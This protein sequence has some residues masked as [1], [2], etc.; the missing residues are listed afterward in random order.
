MAERIVDRSAISMYEQDQ[1]KYFIVINRRRAIPDVR[2]GLKPVQRRVLYGAFVKHLTA[3]SKKRKSSALA[4]IIME[5]FHPHSSCY[6]SIV[7]MAQWFNNKIPMMYGFGNWGSISGSG[8]ASERYTETAL[9]DF[10]YDVMIEELDQSKNIVDWLDTY[11]RDG[12]KEPE[13]LPAKLPML[14]I[15]G[16]FGIGG[17]IQ[18]NIPSHNPNEVIE[19]TRKLLKNPNADVV[20]IPDLCQPCDLI[21]TDW[22]EISHTGSGTFKVRGRIRQEQ[23]KKGNWILHIVSIPD[24]TSTGAIYEKIMDLIENKQLP[25]I[26][27]CFDLLKV[28]PNSVIEEA[29][30]QIHLKPGCDPEYVKQVLYAKTQLQQ[31]VSVNFQVV[32]VNGIDIRRY[33]YRDYLNVFIDQRSYMK[34]RLYCNKLQ[35]AMTKYRQYDAFVKIIESGKINEVMNMI[36]KYK[37]TDDQPIVEFIIKNCNV[38]E[39]QARYLIG[40]NLPRL[41]AGN[42]KKYREARADLK[43]DIDTFTPYVTDDGTMIRKEIDNELVELGKKYNTPRLCRTISASDANNI[44]KGIF[45]VI[46]TERNY[47][48]KIPDVDRVGVVKKDN[49]KFIVR[50]DNTENILI[51]DNKGKVYSLPVSKIP[52]TD[53][54][55]LGTDVRILVRNLT[56][57]I[58][59]VY[60]E[61]IFKKISKSGYKH[62]LVVLSKSNCIKKLDIEDFLT[63]NPSGLIYSK[64]KAD[65]EIVSVCLAPHNLDIVICSDKKALRTNLKEIPLV[66]RNAIGSKA[67]D[68]VEPLMGLSV[69][70]PDASDIVVITKNGKFNRFN[71]AM[72]QPH[73][74]ARKGSGVIKLDSND[75]IFNIFGVNPHDKIRVI[76]AEGAEEILVESI[77]VKSSIAAGTKMISSKGVIVRADLMK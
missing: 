74:R 18:I 20:L 39:M 56:A 25:M 54:S 4:G 22:A 30:I 44:P 69:I 17:G 31:T 37:G 64:I 2:D 28:K 65:D 76:T 36:F 3:P 60:S 42:L 53:K 46:I 41:S 77:K 16:S 62:Y 6:S 33:S 21:D 57:D 51:F 47:I 1:S 75:E 72:L 5:R 71:A 58:I 34:F 38:T 50:I 19:A 55:S 70:Y 9:S 52:I 27:D 45:K 59:S 8:A 63:V 12:D 7:S 49:P 43:K 66:K 35:T 23:D 67:M 73:S 29:D 32:D 48:R 13:Y 11:Q 10:G 15:N 26:K 61:Q 24:N 68:T 14:L 40:V